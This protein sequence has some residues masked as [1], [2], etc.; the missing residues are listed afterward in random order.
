MQGAGPGRLA[1]DLVPFDQFEH[2]GGSRAEPLDKSRPVFGSEQTDQPVGRQPGGGID[3]TDIAA[4]TA[5]ADPFRL[6]HLG[7]QPLLGAV[8]RRR[9]PGVAAADDRHVDGI[10]A[11]GI[12]RNL[13]LGG[14]RFPHG[15]RLGAHCLAEDFR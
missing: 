2:L 10:P 9:E 6:D 11:E 3:E 12:R 15:N 7:R 13:L 8:E 14:R 4:G 5:E 1:S